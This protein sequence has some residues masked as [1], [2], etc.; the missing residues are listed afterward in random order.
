MVIRLCINVIFTCS[1][2]DKWMTEYSSSLFLC[3]FLTPKLQHI[4]NQQYTHNPNFLLNIIVI[5][6]LSSSKYHTFYLTTTYNIEYL[7]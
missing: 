4:H 2:C 6:N 5:Q 7:T 1:F 3:M